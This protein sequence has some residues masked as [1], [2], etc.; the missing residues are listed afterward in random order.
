MITLGGLI[1]FGIF[2]LSTNNVI[3]NQSEAALS[4]EFYISA[5]GLGQSLIDEAKGKKFD[6]AEVAGT[7]NALANL[8]AHASLGRETGETYT[9][10]DSSY[11]GNYRSLRYFDDFDDYNNYRRMVS[12]PRAENFTVS[13]TVG[14]VSETWPDSSLTTKTFAKKMRVTVTSPYLKTSVILEFVYIF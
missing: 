13:S 9:A 10:P 7:L 11:A 5:I 1:L 6:E 3:G 4:N 14:Y 8:T 12:T 2:L